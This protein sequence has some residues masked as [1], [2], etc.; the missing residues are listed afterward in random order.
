MTTP[1]KNVPKDVLMVA[2]FLRHNES[3][4]KIRQGVLNGRRVDYFK[5]KH[6]VNAVLREPYRKNPKRP[7]VTDRA[8]G[9]ALLAKL[10]TYGFFVRVEKTDRPKH[11]SLH[12]I[13]AF[14]PESYYAWV[15]EGSQLKGMLMGMGILLITFAGVMFPL[16]PA[17][18]RQGVYYLSLGLLG[19][20]GVFMGLVVFRLLLWIVLKAATGRD[21]WL[22]PNLFAD[23]GIIDSF[24]PSWGWE[25]KRS[26]RR[27]AKSR[28]IR[29]EG[30]GDGNQEG[31][32]DGAVKED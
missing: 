12:Q 9:D 10:F 6:A 31:A 29:T 22:F 2:D 1:A 3:N 5:G 25:E 32:G 4:L 28:P 20:M 23:V 24:K 16:W 27:S 7:A 13:Q 30:D 17:S 18:L 15:Y 26:S 21:G 19:L 11:V 8:E 14:E